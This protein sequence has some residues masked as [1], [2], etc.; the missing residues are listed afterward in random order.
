MGREG[1]LL[2]VRRLA[3]AVWCVLRLIGALLAFSAPA[4][5]GSETP[6]PDPKPVNTEAP[7][8]TA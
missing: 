5:A 3:R 4:L 6:P 8:L 2:G 1:G 7:K